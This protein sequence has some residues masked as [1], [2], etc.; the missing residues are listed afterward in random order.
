MK[1]LS[2]KQ[3]YILW[4][5]LGL[6]VLSMALAYISIPSGA[7]EV[8]FLDVGQGDSIFIETPGGSQVLIDG[9]APGSGVLGKLSGIMPFYDRHIDI[10]AAT[11]MDADHIGGLIDV[12]ENFEVDMVL[13]ST[14]ISNS[15]LSNKFWQ[16]IKG[17]EIPVLHIEQG[18][19]F[20]LD[21]DIYMYALHPAPH[22]KTK[23]DNDTSLVLKLTYREDSFLFTGDIEKRAEYALAQSGLDI[24]A[25]VLKVPHH[26]SNSSSVEY[27]LAKVNPKLAVIQVGDNRYGHPHP[28]VLRRLQGVQVLRNDINGVI[29]IYS[30]GNSI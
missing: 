10:I 14:N 8:H 21:E 26:G 13:V 7:L 25:D 29:S 23:D 16:V 28:A 11:H 5:F 30:Y 15:P 20:T 24:S 12:I 1:I 22:F 18:D 17:R 27:F 9:G 4:G 3:K 2:K 6:A 19:K